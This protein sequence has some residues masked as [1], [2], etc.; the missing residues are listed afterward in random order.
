MENLP[1][2]ILDK[3]IGRYL[4]ISSMISMSLVCKDYQEIYAPQFRKIVKEIDPYIDNGTVYDFLRITKIGPLEHIV[5][6]FW[7]VV[8]QTIIKELELIHP[9]MRRKTI[10]ETFHKVVPND[11]VETIKKHVRN[12]FKDSPLFIIF[13]NVIY[14]NP[15]SSDYFELPEYFE[16]DVNDMID[17]LI[18][19]LSSMDKNIQR[20]SSNESLT[21]ESYDDMIDYF[22]YENISEAIENWIKYL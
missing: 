16:L 10:I 9:H 21:D 13:N 3:E 20:D 11:A 5:Y 14:R 8:F 12:I 4:D 19:E 7:Y 15:L 18:H 2:E 22:P 1:T 6:K 17:T